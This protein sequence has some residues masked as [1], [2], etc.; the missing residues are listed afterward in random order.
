MKSGGAEGGVAAEFER[1]ADR[2]E[3]LAQERESAREPLRFLAGLNRAQGRAAAAIEQLHRHEPWSGDLR[4]DGE[5]LAEPLRGILRFASENGPSPLA[6]ESAVRA[7]EDAAVARARL[8][9]YWDERPPDFL[10]RALLQPW[11]EVLRHL[12]VR[13]VASIDSSRCAFC[14]GGPWVSSRRGEGNMQGAARFLHCALCGSTWQINR[15]L[16]AACGEKNPDRLP[17]FS[18]ED[19][20]EARIEACEA[21]HRYVKSI[22]LTTDARRMPEVDDVASLALDLWAQEK[23]FSRIEPGPV[24]L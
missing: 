2:A 5:R 20:P 8:C 4:R 1:R 15:I 11:V 14:G 18:T 7:A 17:A 22:D 3:A 9:S 12:G 6:V 16:C 23:G 24:G 13:P 21:C 19:H 10:S